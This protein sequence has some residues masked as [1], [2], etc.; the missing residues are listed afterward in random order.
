MLHI[1]C[2][3]FVCSSHG[4]ILPS[5]GRRFEMT[6]NAPLQGVDFFNENITFQNL[7]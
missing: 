4:F 5:C 7:S 6:L 2:L 3:Q 1:I